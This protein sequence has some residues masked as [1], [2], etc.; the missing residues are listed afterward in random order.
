MIRK[1]V[2]SRKFSLAVSAGTIPLF[3]DEGTKEGINSEMPQLQIAGYTKRKHDMH[4]VSKGICL[5][6]PILPQTSHE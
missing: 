1:G 6:F 3:Y 2:F 5:Q 4:P